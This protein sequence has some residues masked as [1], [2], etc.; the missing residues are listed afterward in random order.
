MGMTIAE[1]EVGGVVRHRMAFRLQ[2]PAHVGDGEVGVG[3]AGDGNTLDAVALLLTGRCLQRIFQ[4]HVTVERVVTGFHDILGIG[5]V[6]GHRHL[7]LI[8]EELTE[9]ER[10][11]DAVLFLRVGG[12]LHH[13]LLQS[14]ET[15][16]D[17]S[18]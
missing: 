3:G 12:A 13:A 18:A 7:R 17:V 2:A 5:I 10:G 8:G 14:A 1:R 9:F 15:I 6:E 4:A 16:A 11:G